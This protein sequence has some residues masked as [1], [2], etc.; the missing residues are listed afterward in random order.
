MAIFIFKENTCFL[1]I[2]KSQWTFVIF[3]FYMLNLWYIFLKIQTAMKHMQQYF[4]TAMT[5]KSIFEEKNVCGE[6]YKCVKVWCKT[7]DYNLSI[8]NY[9]TEEIND[10]G[11]TCTNHTSLSF[12]CSYLN[13]MF[14][15]LI[16]VFLF[17]SFLWRRKRRSD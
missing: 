3:P 10:Q 2:I 5:F 16:L 6:I 11:I 7:S 9:V 4:L 13:L 14:L 8:M 12:D 15:T 1:L 17:Q